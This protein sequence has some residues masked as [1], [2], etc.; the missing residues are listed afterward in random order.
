M[1]DYGLG[2]TERKKD[3]ASEAFAEIQMNRTIFVQQLTSEEQ[4]VPD[5]KQGLDTVDAVFEHYKPNLDIEFDTEEGGSVKE[6]IEFK[7]LGHF[8]PK[9]ITGQSK[10]L[11]DLNAK[12]EQYQKM[13]KNLKSSKPLQAVL[14]NAEMKQAYILAL[15]AMIN[16]L[17]DSGV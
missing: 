17:E 3:G 7:N 1:F 9:G 4:F 11:Q 14:A 5:I 12:T 2:G 13:V 16:E 8:G 10:H 6:N 15:R